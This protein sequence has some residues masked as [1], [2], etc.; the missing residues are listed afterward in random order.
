MKKVSVIILGWNSLSWLK[1]FMAPLAANT[2]A[3]IADIIVADNGSSDGTLGWLEN[4]YP[5]VILHPLGHNHGYAG[6][7]RIAIENIATPYVIL[8]NSDVEVTAGWLTALVGFMEMHP[9][10]G[11]AAPRLRSFSDRASF[12]YAGAAGG[13]I[14]SY[15]YPFCRGRIFSS[16]EQDLGQ[17]NQPEQVFWA[18]GA[19]LMVRTEAYRKAGGLDPVFFAHMEEIDLCWR[20]HSLGYEVW[21]CPESL[22]YHVG[23]GALPNESPRKLFL[24]FRNNLILLRKNLPSNARFRILL[25]RK[26]LDGVAAFQYLFRGK[27]LF[28]M[29]VVKAHIHYYRIW[30]KEYRD[31]EGP[32]HPTPA[33]ISG[34]FSGSIVLAFY[35]KGIRKFSDL[36]R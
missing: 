26:V 34:W 2:P 31:Y 10:A 35:L 23:G 5:D 30:R 27:P 29:A 7:Y 14:D 13:W 24:N 1:Q 25:I 17:Y 11:A 32:V 12:E 22:I 28:F 8:L 3:E 16:I 15:G 9:D 19:C 33:S 4:E 6:G 20:L 18:S 36:M 21:Y